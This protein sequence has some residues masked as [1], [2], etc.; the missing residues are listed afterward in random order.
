MAE[1]LLFPFLPWTS[2]PWSFSWATSS[3]NKDSI[4]EP[5]LQLG[6]ARW[7]CS[8]KERGAPCPSLPGDPLLDGGSEQGRAPGQI[9]WRWRSYLLSHWSYSYFWIW[10]RSWVYLTDAHLSGL[11]TM[12]LTIADSMYLLPGRSRQWDNCY[13]LNPS[14][15]LLFSFC[16]VHVS[17]TVKLFILSLKIS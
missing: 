3:V 16:V 13:F 8:L 14:I 10:I 9:L 1:I 12:K 2:E 6:V 4:S 11:K 15:L 17:E 7:P 5:F